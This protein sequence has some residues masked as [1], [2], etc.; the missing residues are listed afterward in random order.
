MAALTG[1][2]RLA[3][4]TSG[5]RA[6][7]RG[8]RARSHGEDAMVKLGRA[9]IAGAGAKALTSSIIGF[10]IVFAILYWLLGGF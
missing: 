7:P 8:S 6:D 3:C 2:N 10:L 1:A 4:R 5:T 9:L